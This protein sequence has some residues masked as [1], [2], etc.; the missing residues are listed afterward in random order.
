MADEQ[1]TKW[2]PKLVIE[3]TLVGI[4][5]LAVLAWLGALLYAAVWGP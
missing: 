4:G 1:E 2:T 5:C 3:L